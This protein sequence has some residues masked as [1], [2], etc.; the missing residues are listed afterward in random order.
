MTSFWDYHY[1]PAGRLD[2][3]KKDGVV[4]ET[5]GYDDNSNRTS[6]TDFWGSGTATYDD[7]DRLSTYGPTSYTYSANGELLTKTAGPDTTTYGY[8]VLGNLR[9]VT[10]PTGVQIEY[11]IDA[12]N[13][14]IGKKVDGTLVEGFLWQSQLQPAAKLG[15]NGSVVAEFVYATRANV[16]DYLVKNGTTYR[17]F[18]DHLGSVR[19]V[20][21]AS[22]G[23]IAQR[24]DY[25]AFGRITFDSNPGFQPFGFAGGL[26]DPQTGLTRFGARDYDPETGRWTS[27]DPIGFRGGAASVYSYAFSDPQNNIDLTGANP[28][29]A[30][31]A[32][33]VEAGFTAY[34]IYDTFRTLTDPCESALDKVLSA[35]GLLVGEVLPGGGYG[36]GAKTALRHLNE[37]V[38]AGKVGGSA[39]RRLLR[40]LVG[41]LNPEKLNRGGKLQPFSA[42]TGKYLTYDSNPGLRGSVLARFSIGVGEGF[43]ASMAPGVDLPPPATGAQAWGQ[44]FGQVAGTIWSYLH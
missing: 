13:R 11:M 42:S 36:V 17:I 3:V 30:V 12:A 40:N 31:A 9:T 21:N 25:D 34:D 20:V 27:K 26:Y 10:L 29:L 35:A 19:L 5:Y 6:W 15:G 16:P 24:L 8:D 33:L 7:Q 44:S 14:R 18:A 1:D 23:S 37:E 38:E 4:V 43:A 39:L 2:Q 28:L 41:K 22:D 32:V